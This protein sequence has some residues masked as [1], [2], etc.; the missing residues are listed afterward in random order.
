MHQETLSKET[1]IVLNKIKDSVSE[2]Y[3]AG[4]TA[5]ALL[6]GHRISVDLDFFCV[7]NFST[8]E[9]AERLSKQ[10]HLEISSESEGTL[11]GLLDGVKISFFKYPYKLLFP[12]KEYEGVYIADERDIA[13]MKILAISGRGSKKDFVDLFVLLKE[14]SLED[15]LGFFDAKYKEYNY[16]ILHILKSLIY[17]SDADL[18]PEPVYLK[19]ISWDEVKETIKKIVDEYTKSKL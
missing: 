7:E 15:I 16:N 2:F 1:A 13:A 9:I 3:L 18:D 11:N 6:L 14:Y 4:G 5:L 12:K 8:R 10:G 17:F 19:L